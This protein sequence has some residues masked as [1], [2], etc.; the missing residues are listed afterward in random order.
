M[1]SG[2]FTGRRKYI[3]LFILGIMV[4]LYP[5]FSNLYYNYITMRN[6]ENEIL[7]SVTVP[8]D[9]TSETEN[10]SS[11]VSDR[12]F[13]QIESDPGMKPLLSKELSYLKAY[14]NKLWK[15]SEGTKDPFGGDA[16][17]PAD[18]EVSEDA[19]GTSIFA[20]IKIDRIHQTLPVYLGATNEHLKKGAAVIQGTSIPVGG[21]NTNSV[22]A[23]HTGMVQKFFTDLPELKPGDE[24]QIRN[25]WETLYYK[26]TGNK[27]IMPDQEEYLSVVAGKD[28]ITLLT[29]Y[30]GTSKND[31]LL[32]FAERY[33]PEEKTE[34]KS[35]GKAEE[36]VH[37]KGDESLYSYIS[38][39]E[40]RVKPWYEKPQVLVTGIAAILFCL[41]IYT[42][43]S[44]RKK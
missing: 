31:R 8:P 37:E 10:T 44:R 11:T 12:E 39:V 13:R 42:F 40:L 15:D 27:L 32:V 25:R 4:F 36:K 21:E 34:E 1:R 28:M 18:F 43:V 35:E 17:K 30:D 29:C 23:G 20:Y 6:P 2:K 3:L 14:N 19:N 26:V 9:S 5:T 33:Y 41:F 22:I 38:E 7:P 16:G 24:I